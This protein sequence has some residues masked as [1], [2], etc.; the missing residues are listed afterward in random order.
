MADDDP[1]FSVRF[2]TTIGAPMPRFIKT[3]GEAIDVV[4][5]L[6]VATQDTPHW[7]RARGLLYEAY[8]PPS[9][10]AKMKAAEVAFRDALQK[11]RWL[12]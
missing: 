2:R 5:A 10:A 12:N 9:D 8:D 4:N 6:A 11:E 1:V 3:V 7:Q